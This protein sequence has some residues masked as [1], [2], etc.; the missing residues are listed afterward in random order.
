MLALKFLWRS[1]FQ[2]LLFAINQF[3]YV[4][5]RE[6]KGVS[7]RD[8]V[9]RAGFDAIATED[10]ARVVDIV[11]PRI[12]L[13]GRYAI[14]GSV[15]GR[16]DVNAIGRT[17]GGTQETAYAFFE[18]VL[19]AMQNMNPAIARL[20]LNRPVRINLGRG[21]AEHRLQRHAEALYEG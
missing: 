9:G 13:T 8:G 17:S 3:V 18:A 16:F 5:G 15:F 21:F 14:G 10:A 4:I 1:I 12:A 7:V 20:K 2:E 19:V 11:D 6:L